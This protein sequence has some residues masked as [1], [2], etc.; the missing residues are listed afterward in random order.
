MTKEELIRYISARH[1]AVIS[2]IGEDY[3]ESACIEFGNDGLTLIFDTNRDSRKYKIYRNHPK[4]RLSSAGK[5]N[6]QYSMKV[7]QHC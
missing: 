1:L 7:M 4:C 2:T 3:P 5:M 6:E